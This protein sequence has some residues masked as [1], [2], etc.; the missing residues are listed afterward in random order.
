MELAVMSGDQC[1][2]RAWAADGCTPLAASGEAE[3]CQ[4]S[5]NRILGTPAH[6]HAWRQSSQNRPRSVY[7]TP[8]RG[9]SAFG[10]QE[11]AAGCLVSTALDVEHIVHSGRSRGHQ[12]TL[13]RGSADCLIQVR[14]GGAL[15]T[16]KSSAAGAPTPELRR[17]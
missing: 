5:W 3:V 11:A 17:I 7:G 16:V 2:S 6:S 14:T 8:V 12:A 1:R 13:G 15:F 10:P 9:F 4:K